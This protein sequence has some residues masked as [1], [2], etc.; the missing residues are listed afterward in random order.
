MNAAKW[1]VVN[2]KSTITY[3]MRYGTVVISLSPIWYL[4]YMDITDLRRC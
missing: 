4:F 3:I 2:T 1:Y